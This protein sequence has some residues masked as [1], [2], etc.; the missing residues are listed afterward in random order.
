[1]IDRL[2]AV[3]A[4]IAVFSLTACGGGGGSSGGETAVDQ[5]EDGTELTEGGRPSNPT[6]VNYE[7][8]NQIKADSF[9]NNFSVTA[10]VGDELIVTATLDSFITPE[11]SFRCSTNADGFIKIVSAD[12]SCSRHLRYV[13]SEASTYVLAFAFPGRE[14]LFQAAIIKNGENPSLQGQG[15]EGGT[16]DTLARIDFDGENTLSHNSFLN[17]YGFLAEKGE[18]IYLQAYIDPKRSDDSEAFRCAVSGGFEDRPSFGWIILNAEDEI[19]GEAH[20]PKYS[21]SDY[22]E[23]TFKKDGLF[24][25]NFR[26]IVGGDGYF[27]ATVTPSPL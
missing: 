5:E 27:R 15:I 9:S 23:Y 22:L 3:V 8:L 1:M 6:P 12:K 16:P 20:R 2:Q 11:E 24:R 21:C 25:L 10:D 26:S 13:F 17:H 14:G 4:V 18:T 7:G 19:A